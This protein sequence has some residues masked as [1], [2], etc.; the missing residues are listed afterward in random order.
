MSE[1]FNFYNKRTKK[2]DLNDNKKFENNILKNKNAI[3]YDINNESDYYSQ[4]TSKNPL[5]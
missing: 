2:I 3:A 4:K 1:L 5:R